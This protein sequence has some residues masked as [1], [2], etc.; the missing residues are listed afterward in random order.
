MQKIDIKNRNL[1]LTSGF[2]M[3]YN[4][5]AQARR[6]RAAPAPPPNKQKTEPYRLCIYE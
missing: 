6:M 4:F 3:W 5:A 2:V 1:I